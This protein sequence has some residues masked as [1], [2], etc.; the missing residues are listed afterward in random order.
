MILGVCLA[1]C[2]VLMSGPAGAAPDR[3]GVTALT[4]AAPGLR[5]LQMNLCD[6]GFAGCYTGRSVREAAAVIRAVAPEVVTLNEVCRDDVPV[7]E[8]AVA[9]SHHADSD[10]DETTTSAFQAAGDRRTGGAVHCRDG[11]D[12]GIGLVAR[13]PRTSTGPTGGVYP[14]QNARDHEERAWLCLDTISFDACTTHLDNS[15]P[16]VAQAQCD[17]LWR[18]AIPSVHDGTAAAL[19]LGGDLNLAV[20]GSPDVRS[21]L[22]VGY[23]RADDGGVQ[24]VVVS[25][26]RIAARRAID[27]NATTDHPG[28]LVTLTVPERRNRDPTSSDRAPAA[29]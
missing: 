14:V 17:Y 25:G 26:Y 24:H 4:P 28:L 11:Q 9:G 10:D 1:T 18:T 23:G 12:Y 3:D 16:T 15:S 2:F 21:C 13:R 27:L 22:P 5:V 7:I 29:L 8:R 20:G 19:V 6:S